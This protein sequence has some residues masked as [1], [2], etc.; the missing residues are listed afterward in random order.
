MKDQIVKV[1]L[2]S[3]PLIQI[4]YN[5]KR[6]YKLSLKWQVVHVYCDLMELTVPLRRDHAGFRVS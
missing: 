4:P 2:H 3:L 6:E 5:F 1:K